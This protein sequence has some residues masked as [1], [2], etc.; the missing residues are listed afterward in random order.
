MSGLLLG[1]KF[2]NNMLI[3]KTFARILTNVFL[4]NL[5]IQ[6]GRMPRQNFIVPTV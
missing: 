3:K 6:R 4:W 5:F 2:Y 1:L